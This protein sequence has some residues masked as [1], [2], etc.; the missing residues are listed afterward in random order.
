MREGMQQGSASEGRT[1][2]PGE[3]GSAARDRDAKGAPALTKTKSEG[4]TRHTLFSKGRQE[5]G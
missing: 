2:E 5:A 3:G 4:R 1:L